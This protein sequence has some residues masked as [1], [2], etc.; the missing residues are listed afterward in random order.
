MPPLDAERARRPDRVRRADDRRAHQGRRGQAGRAVRSRRRPQAASTMAGS[1]GVVVFDDSTDVVALCARIMKFYAHESCGQC[2][3]C[4]EGTGWLAR[5]CRRLARRRRAS[6][7]TSSCW[8]TSPTASRGNT[9]CALG[10]AAAWPMLGLP[11]QVPRRL[12]GQAGAAAKARTAARRRPARAGVSGGPVNAATRAGTRARRS[13]H[14]LR[15]WP[16]SVTFFAIVT[17]T[18]QQPG[19]RGHVAGRHVLRPGG[20][21]RDA[22]RAL[23]RRRC[24]C[25]STPA[26]SWCCSSSW[27]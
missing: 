27:S 10:D 16:R 15:C 4:R 9:I 2:T 21:L 11:H 19:H 17:I 25:W 1:G 26:R 18:R 12:R 24:R 6:R 7:A 20:D 23:P 5:V 3:P 8:R 13:D 22:V 14:L